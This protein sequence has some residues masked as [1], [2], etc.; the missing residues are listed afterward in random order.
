MSFLIPELLDDD[1]SSTGAAIRP[2]T[3]DDSDT[4]SGPAAPA[5][6]SSVIRPA[7]VVD[8]DVVNGPQAPPNPLALRPIAPATI[9][10]GEIVTGP[11][12]LP[13]PPT[14][15][16]VPTIPA[17]PARVQAGIS[18]A[19]YPL[20]KAIT[21]VPRVNEV[22]AGSFTVVAPGPAVGEVCG[23]D[24]ASRRTFTGLANRITEV[25]VADGEEDAQDVT[26]E[27]DGLLVEFS[28]V[29][30][31]PDFGAS[32]V[33]RLGAPTQDA[34]YFD[35]TM[36][37]LGNES[38]GEEGVNVVPS[39][40]IDATA[41]ALDG[42]FALPDVWPDPR[43]RWMWVANP[44][45][46]QPR[47]WCHFRV[48]TR[49]HRGRLQLWAC[50]YDYAEVWVDGVRM[51]TCDQPGVS[52][53]VDLD[54]RYDFHLV[55]VKAYN[56]RGR[57][58]VLLSLLPVDDDGLYGEP[59][60]ASRS[61][62][63]ALPYTRR[64]F[65][66]TPGQVLYRLRWEAARRGVWPLTG[67]GSWQFD[68]GNLTDSAG[69]PWRRELVVI[70]VGMTYL[71]VLRRLAEDRLDFAAAPDGRRLRCWVKDRGSG[72]NVA[73]PWTATVDLASAAT[74]TVLR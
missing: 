61:N 5:V 56:D 57:A 40:S 43:A 1:T 63:K 72:R 33:T 54:S 14:D 20:A 70:D 73:D 27:L 71:D 19:G 65:V 32:D 23:I 68:F 35:W 17:G 34:R 21:A 55:T 28:E 53:H 49:R 11:W 60:M 18:V 4:V 41:A 9:D 44:R 74:K 62:W 52:Q 12:V 46:A 38:F 48:P 36:N 39:V 42:L 67:P 25:D 31:L 47:G 24:V 22:G 7:S 30:V 29:V 16:T 10:G 15:P 50:A 66:S 37:G 59:I 26:V 58:G 45:E 64:S 13:A 69:R 8:D 3:I 51:M 6:A 2:A